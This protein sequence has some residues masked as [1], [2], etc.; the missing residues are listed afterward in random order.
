MTPISEELCYTLLYPTQPSQQIASIF[1][2]SGICQALPSLCLSSRVLVP[3]AVMRPPRLVHAAHSARQDPVKKRR[4]CGTKNKPSILPSSK[5]CSRT[6][7]LAQQSRDRKEAGREKR[8]R[9]S[10]G[11]LVQRERSDRTSEAAWSY[12]LVPL[13]HRH[14]ELVIKQSRM[15]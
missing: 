14:A 12:V 1:V 4:V 10:G 5:R 13:L 11:R 9:S 3:F 7:E 6:P 15:K 8:L 2:L